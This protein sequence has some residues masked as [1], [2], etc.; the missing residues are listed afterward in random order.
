[1]WK[2]PYFGNENV[3]NTHI[4]RLRLKLKNNA[5]GTM[6]YNRSKG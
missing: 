6:T 5:E 2:E 3:L 1:M 4:S